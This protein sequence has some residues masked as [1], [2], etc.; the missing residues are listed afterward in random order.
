MGK[1]YL[2]DV[3]ETWVHLLTGVFP[4]IFTEADLV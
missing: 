3:L 2:A 1:R 4:W